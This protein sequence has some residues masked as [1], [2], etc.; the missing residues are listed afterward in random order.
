MNNDESVPVI[1]FKKIGYLYLANENHDLN[2]LRENQ[3]V[4]ASLNIPTKIIDAYNL[5]KKFPYL[6]VQDILA[7]SFNTHNEG[8]FDAMTMLH[9]WKK[10]ATEKGV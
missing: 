4:Q 1:P 8:Y 2:I 9:V 6:N 5:S 10:K 7:G 3:K